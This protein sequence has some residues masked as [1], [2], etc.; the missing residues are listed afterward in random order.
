MQTYCNLETARILEVG[1]YDVNGTLRDFA[2]GSTDYVGIDMEQGPGV[3]LVI[4]A[5]DRYPFEDGHFD[6]VMASSV[7]EHDPVF[8]LTFVEMCRVTK[9]GGYLYINAPSNG[10][11][12]RYPL[13]HW[14]FYPDAGRALASWATTQQQAVQLIE[15]FVIDH[16]GEI[17]NDFVGV[18]LKEPSSNKL[19]DFL[20]NEKISCSNVTTY[21]SD[22]VSNFRECPQD[23]RIIEEERA[24]RSELED[25]LEYKKKE[26]SE[27]KD[28][29]GS[30]LLHVESLSEGLQIERSNIAIL[31]AQ[32]ER[33]AA[34]HNSIIDKA[35]REASQKAFE[36]LSEIARL[37]N[38]LAERTAAH[39]SEISEAS[40]E[41]SEKTTELSNEIARLKNS[42]AERTA[43]AE[44]LE[45]TLVQRREEIEQA[46][47][48]LD[49]I[50]K[51]HDE[52]LDELASSKSLNQSLSDKLFDANGWVL[53][54]AKERRDLELSV[55]KNKRELAI[56]VRA[57]NSIQ[58]ERDHLELEIGDVKKH[59][60]NAKITAEAERDEF[61]KK[62][63]NLESLATS[64]ASQASEL[65]EKVR[66]NSQELLVTNDSL[67]R[68]SGSL[69][70]RFGE[71]AKVAVLLRQ[72]EE[73]SRGHAER[74]DWLR[75]VN[76]ALMAAPQSWGL[77]PK[78]QQRK[79]ILD[80]LQRKGL[81]DGEAYLA[82]HADVAAKRMD[83]LVHYMRHGIGEGRS[84]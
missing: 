39:A 5:G 9:P 75:Q 28:E 35:G 22:E 47:A 13:D 59:L 23:M 63:E 12:H 48:N 62:I 4:K 79:R 78:R 51:L 6:L 70:D 14:R 50:A 10:L 76:A 15:S 82:R 21:K 36:F 81:F 57:R 64:A 44:R 16:D 60:A 37:E 72:E 53:N 11:Y 56:S 49:T 30:T 52:A 46:W 19:P 74:A 69:D 24:R 66:M 43:D 65:E 8:W 25:D 84:L 29:I 40:R 67:K 80:L 26:L 38:T 7:F 73:S 55:S 1:S 61:T 32:I 3:D 20:I 27:L 71:L 2:L 54:L 83:P 77:L 34:D 41:A 68:I 18:F 31:S 33:T 42:L 58:I 17:F 45:N